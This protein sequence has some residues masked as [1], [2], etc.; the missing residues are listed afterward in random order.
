MCSNAHSLRSCCAD[1]R[2]ARLARNGRRVVYWKVRIVA[3]ALLLNAVLAVGSAAHVSGRFAQ[4]A[5]STAWQAGRGAAG[6]NTYVGVIDAPTNGATISS[7]A[8][9]TISGWFV[10]TTAQGWAG[11][12]DVQVFLGATDSGT[13][14]GRGTVGVARRD[15]AAALGNPYWSAAGWQAVVDAAALPLGAV[16]LSV[17]IHTPTKGWWSLPL[18]ITVQPLVSS[19][20]EILAP[21]PGTQGAP[22]EVSVTSPA[23]GEYVSTRLRHFTISG[24]A[25]DPATGPRGV[26]WVE[27]WLNGEANTEGAVFLA[28]IDVRGDG[29]WSV[30]FDPDLY[31]PIN[32]NLY[33]Y[34]HSAVTGKRTVQVV[35]FYLSDRPTPP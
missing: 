1:H 14:L 6:D 34:A 30:D 33:A 27:L 22:P 3:V 11:A 35:H 21:A 12:D 20:G 13:L 16:G 4:P 29:T 2:R 10:D 5:P 7:S 9:F 18:A 8:L 15:V 23:A 19:T 31:P 28:N 17:A 25:R 26:D 24:T 32:V